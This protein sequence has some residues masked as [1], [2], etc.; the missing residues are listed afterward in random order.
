MVGVGG[1]LGIGEKEVVLLPDEIAFVVTPD[2]I[3][4][5]SGLSKDTLETREKAAEASSKAE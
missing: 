2:R 4:V 3:A 5:V 1:F